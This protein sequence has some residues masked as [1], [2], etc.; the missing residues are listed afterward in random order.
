MSIIMKQQLGAIMEL[1]ITL[2]LMWI[3]V[4]YSDGTWKSGNA[5]T[6]LIFNKFRQKITVN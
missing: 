5:D 3:F 4:K 1:I 2:S 6:N